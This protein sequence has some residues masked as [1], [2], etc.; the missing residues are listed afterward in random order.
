MH[1]MWL[2]IAFVFRFKIDFVAIYKKT[3]RFNSLSHMYAFAN[4]FKVNMYENHFTG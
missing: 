1:G 3:V 4:T 2:I